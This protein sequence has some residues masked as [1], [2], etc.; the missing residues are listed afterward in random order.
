[1]KMLLAALL[2]AA[3]PAV[4][5]DSIRIGL[6]VDRVGFAK[7]WSEPITQG[8]QYAARELNAKGG[9]LGRKVELVIEDDQSKPEMSALAA[10]KL[11]GA[12][13]AFI[14][15]LTHTVAA[16]QA[17]TVTVETK[18]PHLAPSLTVDT[19]TTQINNPNFWQTGPL[20]STQIATL[21]SYARQK[22]YKRVALVSDNSAI[23]QA[24]GK[25]F[26]AEFD[27][28]GIQLVADEV[29]PSGA[30]SADAQ[31]QKVR[32]ANPEAIF[33]ATLLTPENLL[34]LRYYRSLGM[35]T[36]LIGNYNLAVPVYM[37]VAKGLLDGLIF[38]DVWDP[39][40]P[41]V[42]QFIAGYAKEMGAE[43]HNLMGY[44]YDG[45]M[46][47]ADAIRRA[48]STDKEKVRQAMQGTRGYRGVLG[49]MESSYGFDDGKRI[50]FDPQ[51][52]VVRM[53][54]GDRQGRV[55][56]VGTK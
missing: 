26:K 22:N 30:Q 38:V 25:A 16:L 33:L 51:G 41:Q 40:K 9:I 19:L 5:Q 50:G 35:K 15:S 18:T 37:T 32:A 7:A 52:M 21:L 44:G 20:A 23:S 43:P 27:K 34:V 2:V 11:E 45:V 54:E 12:G 24:T 55:L 46:M 6:I 39:A 56:H 28:N 53:Y 8:T 47:A 42:K 13:V 17:Q 14:L 4:A 49:S 36:P 1:V 48:G 31:M 29:L 10:R 3:A